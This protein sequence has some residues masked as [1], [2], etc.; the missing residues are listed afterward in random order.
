MAS[1][2]RPLRIGI[3]ILL[4]IV[5]V[6]LSY[7]LYLSI[8]EPYEAVEEQQRITSLTRD[9]MGD[10][11]TALVR[12]ETVNG[13]YPSSLDSLIAFVRMDSVLSANPDSV[14]GP[15]FVPDSLPYSP[16]TGDRFEYAVN[17]TSRVK[18]YLIKDPNSDDRIGTIEGEVTMLNAASWE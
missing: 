10:L 2:S 18:S 16:R 3:Q 4:A 6:G 1:S 7:W 14:F 13:R 5:I 12:F 17:D 9:R 15:G 11:R 8:T